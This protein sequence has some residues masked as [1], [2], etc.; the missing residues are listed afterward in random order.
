MPL[1][2]ALTSPAPVRTRIKAMNDR[3]TKTMGFDQDK[4]AHHFY[5][6]DDGGTIDVRV[7]D[8]ADTKELAAIRS[9]LPHI[10]MMFQDGNFEAPMLVH[11]AEVRAGRRRSCS[12]GKDKLTLYLLRDA[13]R[14]AGSAW[15]RPTPPP[16]RH[17]TSS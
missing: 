4:T 5:L 3:G 14:A 17:S 12:P 10:A 7:K 16:A 1:L 11:D 13:G 2:L 15:S 8:A 6:Y 9:H